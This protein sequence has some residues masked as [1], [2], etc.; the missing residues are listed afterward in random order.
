VNNYWDLNDL[1][2][3][4]SHTI[5]DRVGTLVVSTNANRDDI[6]FWRKANDEGIF[7]LGLLMIYI[8]SAVEGETMVSLVYF[9][10]ISKWS[11]GLV[12]FL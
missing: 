10:C 6:L 1:D 12:C 11:E 4:V 7:R 9:V 8:V 2:I 3:P 5:L